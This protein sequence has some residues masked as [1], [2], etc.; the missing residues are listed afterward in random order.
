[1]AHQPAII[2]SISFQHLFN[3]AGGRTSNVLQEMKKPSRG[4]LRTLGVVLAGLVAIWLIDKFVPS[5]AVRNLPKSA[6]EIQEYYHEA[7]MT[8]DFTRLLKARVPKEAV[9]EYARSVG[10]IHKEEGR[11][12]HDYTS[13]VG[14]GPDWWDPKEPPIFYFYEG[15]TRILVGWENGFVYYDASST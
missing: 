3:R 7:G 1:M 11:A 9:P 15:D 8:V 10:A 4:C 14:H 5:D 13:W 6:S 2:F 12:G